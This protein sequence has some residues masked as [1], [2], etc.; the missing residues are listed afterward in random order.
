MN[1]LD[2]ALSTFTARLRTLLPS[3]LYFA[4]VVAARGGNTVG[5]LLIAT[6]L[7]FVGF[8]PVAA[9]IS[10]VTLFTA[11][12][13]SGLGTVAM[14]N[15]SVAFLRSAS[16][17][18]SL[19]RWLAGWTALTGLGSAAL[20][21]LL[22]YPAARFSLGD[23]RFWP[24][25]ALA[26]VSVF[27]GHVSAVSSGVL[28]A[29]RRFRYLTAANLSYGVLVLIAC[30]VAVELRSA[31]AAVLGM[32]LAAAVQ[33][34]IGCWGIRRDFFSGRGERKPL[35]PYS[36]R[37]IGPDWLAASAGGTILTAGQFLTL[38]LLKDSPTGIGA[39]GLFSVML[40]MVNIFLFVPTQVS[41][42]FFQTLVR[43]TKEDQPARL[44]RLTCFVALCGA[45]FGAASLFLVYAAAPWIP[46]F[47]KVI[48]YGPMQPTIAAFAIMAGS[49]NAFLVALYVASGRYGR[50][51][52][53]IA[54]GTSTNLLLVF[55]LRKV[56]PEAGLLGVTGGYFV[57]AACAILFVRAG[58]GALD[59]SEMP[60]PDRS[61]TAAGF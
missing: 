61:A 33:T 43:Y 7:G 15:T 8:A 30:V 12:I 60:P 25:F 21:V 4:G 51:S 38:T 24:L 58:R 35:G 41:G 19:V 10:F 50:W 6:V 26:A 2:V 37:A 46:I 5:L 29:S 48:A 3:A 1:K 11:L 32:G 13:G 18:R 52:V 36:L 45:A 14:R 54:A 56:T 28:L 16:E 59:K 42:Y 9:V 27:A 44:W 34:A 39:I 22:A 23:G 49:L 17:F 55:M 20:A 53:F 47:R 31:Q 57:T 40:Q